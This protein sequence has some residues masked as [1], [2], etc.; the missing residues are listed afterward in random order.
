MTLHAPQLIYLFLM[1]L[2]L[3]FSLAKNGEPHT[4][5]YSFFSAL[6]RSAIVFGILYW[7]GFFG[8]SFTPPATTQ[9]TVEM[10][11]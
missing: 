8:T 7:G 5:K 4:E 6:F 10:A 11:R 1:L 3:G 2:G 9:A